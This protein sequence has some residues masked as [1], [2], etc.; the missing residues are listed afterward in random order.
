MLW[1]MAG[2]TALEQL[3]GSMTVAQLARCAGITIDDIVAV[4]VGRARTTKMRA[5]ANGGVRPHEPRP[6]GNKYERAAAYTAG[7]ANVV[8]TAKRPI[9]SK[10]IRATV[11]GNAT[12]CRLALERLIAA[13]AIDHDGGATSAR[14]YHAA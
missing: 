7:V 10:E 1:P 12:R 11:G 2:H 14:R 6:S 13:G 9:S 3:V 5:P 4:T 8:R